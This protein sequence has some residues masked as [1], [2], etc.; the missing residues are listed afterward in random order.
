MKKNSFNWNNFNK[1]A[2]YEDAK[3]LMQKQTR[4]MMNCYKI[5]MEKGIPYQEAIESCIEEFQDS[6]SNDWSTKYA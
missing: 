6:N 1:K 4:S 2:N 3:G 5:K